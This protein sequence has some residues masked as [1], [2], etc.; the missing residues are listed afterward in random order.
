MNVRAVLAVAAVAVLAVSAVI[1]MGYAYTA[2]TSSDSN[3][4]EPDRYIVATDVYGHKNIQVPQ[5]TYYRMGSLWYPS[6]VAHSLDFDLDVENTADTAYIRMF[7]EFEN[8]MTWTVIKQCSL[9]VDGVQYV[10]YNNP[11]NPM[12]TYPT[13]A[14]PID[15]TV[16]HTYRM[17]VVYLEQ[18][19]FD[20]ADFV[21]EHMKSKVVFIQSDT[22]PMTPAP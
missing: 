6:S 18:V 21:G 17:E 20:P 19:T 2:V 14:I 1:G 16:A 22:D 12:G 11:S 4:F 8:P 5:V 13:T 7:V 3:E 9:Y 15:P 10:F